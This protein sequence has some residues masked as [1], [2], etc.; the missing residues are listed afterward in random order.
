ML[1]STSA[2]DLAYAQRCD[3]AAEVAIDTGNTKGIVPTI[4]IEDA[5]KL[6]E[7]TKAAA[8][9]DGTPQPPGHMPAA[10]APQIPDWYQVGWRAVSKIDQGP[11]PEGEEKERS[12]LELFLS[13]QYYGAW[14]HNAA[15]I[16]F[17]GLSPC[18]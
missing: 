4:T 12:V 8:D 5:D 15:L 11:L 2:A 9:E 3:R 1:G 7:V 18:F 10:Q 6:K 13:E 14:Y 16:V 17:V